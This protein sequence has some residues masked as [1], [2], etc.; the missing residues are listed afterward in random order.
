VFSIAS[1]PDDRDRVRITY[2]VKGA[3]TNRMER[4]LRVGVPAWI[5]LPYGDFV[6][7]RAVDVVLFAGGTGITAFTAYLGSLVGDHARAVRL[8]YGART[9]EL[10]VYR[11]VVE[12]AAERVPAVQATF[13]SEAT[14]GRLSADLAWPAVDDLARPVFYLSGPPAMLTA[15]SG[16]LAARG[17]PTEDIRID[18]WE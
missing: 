5:K 11:E 10:F 3:F 6:I 1:L 17:I 4:E 14:D 9:P 15:L 2:A 12:A 18:A 7:D 16:G 8:Y 13:V